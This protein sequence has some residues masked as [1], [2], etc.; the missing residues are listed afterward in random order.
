MQSKTIKKGK[1]FSI[2]ILTGESDTKKYLKSFHYMKGREDNY[3]VFFL[4]QQISGKVHVF[5][6]HKSKRIYELSIEQDNEITYMIKDKKKTVNSDKQLIQSQTLQL[7][8]NENE[9]FIDFSVTPYLPQY[10]SYLSNNIQKFYRIK[11]VLKT[12]TTISKSQELVFSIIIINPIPAPEQNILCLNIHDQLYSILLELNKS[13]F[14]NCDA[15]SGN[16][17]FNRENKGPDEL[18]S[19]LFIEM[20]VSESF[21]NYVIS[22]KALCKYQLF[23]GTPDNGMKAPFILQLSP[24]KLWPYSNKDSLK[25]AFHL[26]LVAVKSNELKAYEEKYDFKNQNSTRKDSNTSYKHLDKVLNLYLEKI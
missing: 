6:R 9:K 5:S 15:L 17:V 1:S 24:M 14:S 7:S 2:E 23:D 3:L 11:A 25:V 21:D 16:I 10:E 12:Q 18:L 4:N 20:I 8:E 13:C 26:K 19:S 22:E